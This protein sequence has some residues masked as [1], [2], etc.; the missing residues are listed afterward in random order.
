M[1]PVLTIYLVIITAFCSIRK[2]HLLELQEWAA[3]KDNPAGL[4]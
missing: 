4:Q 2:S 3:I 1:V